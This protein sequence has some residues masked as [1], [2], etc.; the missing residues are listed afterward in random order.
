MVMTTLKM[1]LCAIFCGGVVMSSQAA[2]PGPGTQGLVAPPLQGL[3][4]GDRMQL[5]VDAKGGRIEMDC[6]SGTLTGPL[7]PGGDGKFQATG[8]FEQ[9]Q[10][11]PQRADKAA[12]AVSARFVGE[13]HAGAMTLTILTE[14][15]AAPQVFNLREGARVKLVRCL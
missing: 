15:G 12:A 2:G 13:L 14:G 7:N 5:T 8:T 1:A 3:W 6:A 10:P 11:G 4:A 9:H